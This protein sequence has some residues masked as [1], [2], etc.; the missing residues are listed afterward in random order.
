MVLRQE[1]GH[2]VA[3]YPCH[4]QL[5]QVLTRTFCYQSPVVLNHIRF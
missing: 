1:Q 2:V 4:T 5:H 3:Y